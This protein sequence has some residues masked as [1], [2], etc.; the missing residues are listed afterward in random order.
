MTTPMNP[1]MIDQHATTMVDDKRKLD[2]EVMMTE[3]DDMLDNDVM[4]VLLD[5]DGFDEG[6]M[7]RDTSSGSSKAAA[8]ISDE[9][10]KA[11]SV[12]S[13]NKTHTP[14]PRLT[15]RPSIQL[16]LS[17]NPDHLSP[18]QCLIR[19]NIE[20]FEATE[21]DL[22]GRVKGRNRPIVLGQVGIRCRHCANVYPV[23]ERARGAMYYPH[24]L[25]GIYQAAQILSQ[26]HFLS[27]QCTFLPSAEREEMQTLKSQKSFATAGKEYWAATA[28]V[29][30]VYED[31][32]GLRFEER[33][34]VMRHS[35]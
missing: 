35:H 17:C 10:S 16:Y 5:I 22:E 14:V 18:Y 30:G 20:L 1:E 13:S 12:A 4:D 27:G 9:E 28:K 31:Q 32:H 15:G 23:E 11:S 8:H 33:L 3:E 6:G 26:G 24:E 21:K 19:R 7:T 29:L 2:D 25:I 34:G